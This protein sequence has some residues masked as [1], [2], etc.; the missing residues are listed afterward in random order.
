LLAAFSYNPHLPNRD[1]SGWAEW[2]E[3]DVGEREGKG[4]GKGE[5][6][7]ETGGEGGGGWMRVAGT[8]VRGL[9]GGDVSGLVW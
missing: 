5:G 9:V 8:A 1:T 4:G 6:E 2:K 3:E 7:R